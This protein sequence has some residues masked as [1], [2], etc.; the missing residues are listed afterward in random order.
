MSAST[1][2]ASSAP[3]REEA[4]QLRDAIEKRDAGAV[5]E[6]MTQQRATFKGR[7]LE[8][9]L[10]KQIKSEFARAQ[11]A[12]TDIEPPRGRAA[13]PTRPGGPTTR[14]SNQDGARS[15]AARFAGGRRAWRAT[16]GIRS[17]NGLLASVLRQ[18][19]S[20][21]LARAGPRR[22]PRDRGE[23]LPSSTARPA[24]ARAYTMTAIREAYEAKATG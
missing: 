16:T 6:L 1:A 21:D 22:S 8:R 19:S 4:N 20:T 17:A 9:A 15:R 24:P 14:Y 10:G 11:F 5:L 12:E 2:A 18:E 3:A 7:D 23:G 13:C